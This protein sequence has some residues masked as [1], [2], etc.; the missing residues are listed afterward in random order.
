MRGYDSIPKV[1]WEWW[2]LVRRSP[3]YWKAWC[4]PA[5]AE[6]QRCWPLVGS[7]GTSG[8]K[9]VAW[10]PPCALRRRLCYGDTL[11]YLAH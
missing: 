4:S 7:E 10:T 5:A 1:L 9:Q 3:V 6:K 11:Y 2:T 8:L